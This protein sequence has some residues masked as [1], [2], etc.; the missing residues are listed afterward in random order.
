[1]G[2]NLEEA[3]EV[4][5]LPASLLA[6][7]VYA[8][9]FDYPLTVDE[10]ARYQVGTT[11]SPEEIKSA[12]ASDLWLISHIERTGGYY[13]L[14][15]RSDVARLRAERERTSRKL[16]KKAI[17]YSRWSS[18]L[19]FVRMVAVTGALAVHNIGALPDIDLLVIAQDNRVWLCRRALIFCVRVARLMGDDLCPNYV[20]AESNLELDQRDFF[21][22]HE[23]AQMVPMSGLGSYRRLLRAN[24][25]AADYLPA[26]FQSTTLSEHPGGGGRARTAF[27]RLFNL[28]LFDR[29]E[30]WELRRLQAKLKPLLGEEAEVVCSPDQCKGHTGLHRRR[31]MVRYRDAL[32]Q[33]GLSERVPE[34]LRRD[35]LFG[36]QAD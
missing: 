25:W 24:N 17:R 14:K 27:E 26:A 30:K 21:T 19:P 8:A 36:P 15:G 12:L 20:I 22:A 13:H 7:L 2:P 29:W 34:V 23:L 28:R 1:M 18:R 31:V 16:W 32:E 5:V 6:A 9:L 10:L 35:P 3:Q 4:S 33:L 11:F